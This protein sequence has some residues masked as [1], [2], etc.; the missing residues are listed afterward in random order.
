VRDQQNSH[1]HSLAPCMDRNYDF[2]AA[3]K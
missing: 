1:M 3:K 2:L